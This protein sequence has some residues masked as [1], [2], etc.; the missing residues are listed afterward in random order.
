LYITCKLIKVTK[1]QV[2]RLKKKIAE[3]GAA[4]SMLLD[5]VLHNDMKKVMIEEATKEI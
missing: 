3:L 5:N 1:L 2:S 4:N